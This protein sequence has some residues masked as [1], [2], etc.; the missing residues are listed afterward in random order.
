MK[1]IDEIIFVHFPH[2]FK[3]G[4]PIIDGRNRYILKEVSS[5]FTEIEFHPFS[6]GKENFI[7]GFLYKVLCFLGWK[8]YKELYK[9]PIV[10][11]KECLFF[12]S[13]SFFGV[14]IKKVKEKYPNIRIASFFHNIESDY[15]KQLLRRKFNLSALYYYILSLR[16]EKKTVKYSDIIFVLNQRDSNLLKHIYGYSKAIL[17]PTT[18]MDRFQEVKKKAINTNNRL[19]ILFVGTYFPSNIDGVKWLA[20]K[21]APY[22]N[23]DFNIVGRGMDKLAPSFLSNSNIHITGEVNAETLDQFYYD[24][25]IFISTLFS[26]GGMKTKIAEAMMFALPIIGTDE[27]FQGYDIDYS[28]IGLKSD[29]PETIISFINNI[30]TDRS[31]LEM[32]SQKSRDYFTQK[33]SYQSSFDIVN[34]VL[35]IDY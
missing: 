26:G 34:T 7:R 3:G 30:D 9:T 22:V 19:K 35:D 1:K 31:L 29:N 14:Y 4:L 12:F 27:A 24:T 32:Y 8:P 11:R 33:Y 2:D 25:D 20:D 5:G 16:S 13:H 23:A 6:I 28:L 10:D 15:Q 17:L 18:L 21:I